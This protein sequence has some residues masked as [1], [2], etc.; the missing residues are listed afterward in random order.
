MILVFG[1]IAA[2]T[3]SR[4]ALLTAAVVAV[5]STLAGCA[6]GAVGTFAGAPAG[7]VRVLASFYPLQ[8]VAQQVGG[9]RVRVDS[10]TPPGAEPHDIELSPAQVS[11]L[12]T[13]D[14]VVVHSA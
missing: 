10:L 12:E 4:R 3:R 8:C 11:A 1:K 6:N 9:D 13:A 5:L 2:M 7:K 14:L